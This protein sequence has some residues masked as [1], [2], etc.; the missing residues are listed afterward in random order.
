MPKYF[1][2]QLDLF[3][4]TS[5]PQEPARFLASR[6]SS[7]TAPIQLFQGDKVLIRLFLCEPAAEYRQPA[8]L[9]GNDGAI[10]FCVKAAR[11]DSLPP[12]VQTADFSP[13]VDA[14]GDVHYEAPLNLNVETLNASISDA[15]GALNVSLDVELQSADG[16][17]RKS[18]GTAARIVRQVYKGDEPD[19][20]PPPADYPPPDALMTKPEAAAILAALVSDQLPGLLAAAVANA[21]ANI[22]ASI[23]RITTAAA[24]T[25]DPGEDA[26]A[27]IDT[28][29]SELAPADQR[30]TLGIPRGADSLSV[31]LPAQFISGSA[32]V[33]NGAE[34]LAFTFPV[35]FA[36]APVVTISI[37]CPSGQPLI[38]TAITAPTSTGFTALFAAPIPGT[39]YTLHYTASASTNQ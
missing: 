4:D 23:P 18:F 19:T 5:G 24:L 32:T 21:T 39:G 3:L 13:V 34:S 17:T 26:T 1:L 8:I 16:L 27:E 2:R 35:P 33:A 9:I 6:T 20:P 7:Q 31:S 12:L 38:T 25:L 22:A 36:A 37:A 11:D 30:L 28:P 10:V 15:T 29:D 14:A